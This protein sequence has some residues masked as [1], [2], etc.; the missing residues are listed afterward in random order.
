MRY[1][2]WIRFQAVSESKLVKIC[3]EPEI[4]ST[5]SDDPADFQAKSVWSPSVF[6]SQ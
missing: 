1:W 2:Q 3:S 5:R 4:E 6:Q